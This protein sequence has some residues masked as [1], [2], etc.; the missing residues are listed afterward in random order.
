MDKGK[1]LIAGNPLKLVEK[2][3]G[4]EVIELRINRD[5]ETELLNNLR[6]FD[7]SHE[8]VGDTL[9]LFSQDGQDLLKFLISNDYSHLLHRPATLEDLFL[10]LTG[11][12]LKE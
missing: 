3:I 11:R 6:D 1:I 9:C 2:Q 5:K 10:K 4:K 12:G 8:R 7:F